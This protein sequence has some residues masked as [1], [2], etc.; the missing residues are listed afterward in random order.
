MSWLLEGDTGLG[1][2]RLLGYQGYWKGT[3]EK[4]SQGWK[5][6][7]ATRGERRDRFLKA[8]GGGWIDMFLKATR[9]SKLQKGDEGMGFQGYR[10]GMQG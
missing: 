9:L 1:F 5:A 7:K 10:R 4:V 8:T 6:I 3:H 2:S